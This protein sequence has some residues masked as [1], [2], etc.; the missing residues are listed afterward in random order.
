MADEVWGWGRDE[1]KR[2]LKNGHESFGKKNQLFILLSFY[3]EH[4][5]AW[6][7]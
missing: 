4:F 2:R 5:T 3:W 6:Q 7:F 1:R